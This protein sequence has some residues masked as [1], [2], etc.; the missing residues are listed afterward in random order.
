MKNV[1][2]I[3]TFAQ[4]TGHVVSYA[5]DEIDPTTGDITKHNAKGSFFAV[6]A[7]IEATVKTLEEL[8]SN[9]INEE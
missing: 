8:V 9:K 3:Q 2:T 7:N 4:G 5:Y 6:D 1:K